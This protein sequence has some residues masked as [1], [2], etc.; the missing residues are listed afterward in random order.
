MKR[1][2]PSG[3]LFRD[4]LSENSRLDY[5]LYDPQRHILT[6]SMRRQK[7]S[8]MSVPES[9]YMHL[10]L[11]KD[12]DSIFLSEIFNKYPVVIEAEETS[13]AIRRRRRSQKKRLQKE[14]PSDPT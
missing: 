6:V 1:P 9:A 2:E 7:L 8:Y 5:V 3:I 14:D 10:I 13:P 12:P 11:S 4:L